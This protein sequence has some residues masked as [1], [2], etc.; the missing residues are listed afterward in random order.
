MY[1]AAQKQIGPVS[2]ETQTD[3]TSKL[4]FFFFGVD[5]T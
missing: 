5:L 3:L 1:L 2:P 4:G